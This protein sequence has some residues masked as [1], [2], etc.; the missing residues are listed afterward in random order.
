[1]GCSEIINQK[2]VNSAGLGEFAQSCLRA[3]VGKTCGQCWKCFRKNSLKGRR[4]SISKE[5]DTF[6]RQDKL[7]MAASTIYSI[8]KMEKMDIKL[9]SELI[10]N[11]EHLSRLIYE[12]VTFLEKF[13]PPA[14]SLIPEKYR[15]YVKSR[16]LYYEIDFAE[17]N[18][19]EN[20][21]LYH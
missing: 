18:K 14:L 3:D 21:D 2:I 20:F 9:F 7:K 8:Q 16:L 13:Y 12:D 11:Y 19:L 5:I 10:K 4:V 6:L 15:E 1:M 17:E